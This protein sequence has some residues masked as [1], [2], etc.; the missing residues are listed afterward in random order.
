MRPNNATKAATNSG[1]VVGGEVD[2]LSPRELMSTAPKQT[3]VCGK[4]RYQQRFPKLKD[5]KAFAST[6]AQI[7]IGSASQSSTSS[8]R[9]L[10]RRGRP[11]WA[12]L[13]RPPKSAWLHKDAQKLGRLM[14]VIQPLTN[15]LSSHEESAPHFENEH[16]WDPDYRLPTGPATVASAPIRCYDQSY[17]PVPGLYDSRDKSRS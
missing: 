2:T 8:K 15:E 17:H 10:N 11:P 3:N 4:P 9:R 12:L 1:S 6:K 16:G 14:Q 7:K 5:T 13:V